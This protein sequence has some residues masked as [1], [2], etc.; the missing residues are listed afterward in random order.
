MP[1]GNIGGLNIGATELGHALESDPLEEHIGQRDIGPGH[2]PG[3]LD[4]AGVIGRGVEE[5]VADGLMEEL[6]QMIAQAGGGGGDSIAG[7][8]EEASQLVSDVCG[9]RGG[10]VFEWDSDTSEV[11][12][13]VSGEEDCT[14]AAGN[15][16]AKGLVDLAAQLEGIGADVDKCQAGTGAAEGIKGD[17]IIEVG[18]GRQYRVGSQEVEGRI[19]GDVVGRGA[20]GA[21]DRE[22]GR[23]VGGDAADVRDGNGGLDDLVRCP[24]GIK[25]EK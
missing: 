7:E 22:R 6:I 4:G 14:P 21:V 25:N 17:M 1:Q 10:V 19:D 12:N 15:R 9:F 3:V 11:C 5:L 2:L 13:R 20:S 16:S 8:G 23:A 24:C 18:F